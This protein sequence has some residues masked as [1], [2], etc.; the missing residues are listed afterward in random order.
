VELCETSEEYVKLMLMDEVSKERRYK[1]AG[2]M[3]LSFPL[4]ENR[5]RYHLQP[6]L[7]LKPSSVRF[8]NE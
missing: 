6:T 3:Y 7:L 8:V 2:F 4:F 1:E 5:S